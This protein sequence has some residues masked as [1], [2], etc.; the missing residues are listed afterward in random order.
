MYT[1]GKK[2]RRLTKTPKKERST[3]EVMSGEAD[4]LSHLQVSPPPCCSDD[5]S[6]FKGFPTFSACLGVC[7]CVCVCARVC[8]RYLSPPPRCSLQVLSH[9]RKPNISRLWEV[10]VIFSLICKYFLS[11]NL[12]T[13]TTDLNPAWPL[14]YMLLRCVLTLFQMFP[15]VF[16]PEE[17]IHTHHIR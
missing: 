4:A 16:R 12:L 5:T 8:V 14:L 15:T 2:C 6:S 17:S 7:V 13:A 10:I 3:V 1:E 11:S 9:S